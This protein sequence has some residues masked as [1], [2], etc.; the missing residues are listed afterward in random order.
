VIGYDD[1]NSD[2]TQAID[3]GPIA[4]GRTNLRL[5]LVACRVVTCPC[6]SQ[7]LS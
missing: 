3:I 4:Q 5:A 7:L 6:P 2:R 1:G